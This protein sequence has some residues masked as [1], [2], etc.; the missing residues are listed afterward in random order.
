[1][2]WEPAGAILASLADSAWEGMGQLSHVHHPPPAQHLGYALAPTIC[3]PGPTVRDWAM[4]WG[5]GRNC[6]AKLE[7]GR[8][9]LDLRGVGGLQGLA[10]TP[11]EAP[12]IRVGDLEFFKD[13]GCH[14]LRSA[15]QPQLAR[16]SEEQERGLGSGP[17]LFPPALSSHREPSEADGAVLGGSLQTDTQS[18]GR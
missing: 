9:C 13:I 6:V 18:P 11:R 8:G 12:P 16:P 17:Q 14:H 15:P 7:R 3:Q 5:G 2:A 10:G 1:M 4:G